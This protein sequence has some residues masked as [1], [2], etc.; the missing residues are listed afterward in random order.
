MCEWVYDN[1]CIEYSGS[2]KESRKQDAL[3]YCESYLSV[4]D[5]TKNASK[6]D[7]RKSVIQTLNKNK[8]EVKPPELASK[9]KT[10]RNELR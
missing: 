7:K 10:E 9:A 1:E 2:E 4:V 8:K 5:E 6:D 3:K